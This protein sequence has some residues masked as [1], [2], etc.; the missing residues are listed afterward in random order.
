MPRDDDHRDGPP[1]RRDGRRSGRRRRR[2]SRRLAPRPADGFTVRRRDATGRS[3]AEETSSSRPAAFHRPAHPGG[4]RGAA[5]PA[6]DRST[7]FDYRREADLPPGA[8]LVVGSGQT[9]VQLAEELQD[10][11]REVYPVG[12]DAPAGSRGDIAAAT[13]SAGSAGSRLRGPDVGV[14]AAARWSSCL[15]PRAGSTA[16]HR[17][18]ATRAVTAPTCGRWPTSGITLVGRIGGVDGETAGAR[19]GPGGDARPGRGDSSARSSSRSSTVH[20]RDRRGC[21]GRRQRLVDVPAAGA[22][23]A[24]PAPGRHLDGPLVERLPP[25][26]RLDGRAGSST[27]WACPRRGAASATCRACSSSASCGRRTRSS[28]TLFGPRVDAPPRRDRDGPDAAARRGRRRPARL[29][30]SNDRRPPERRSLDSAE[31]RL[32]LPP[33]VTL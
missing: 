28:A 21:P 13:S 15:S 7:R 14:D 30:E 10:A 6:R 3:Q 23:V 32:G 17:S 19:A 27:R 22:R 16:T 1:L 31:R 20:R 5:G 2:R 26:L 29:T 8:V 33:S 4:R 11:G 25:R 24:R 9:G 12:R 18:R